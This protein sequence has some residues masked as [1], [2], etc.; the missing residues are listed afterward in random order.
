[1]SEFVWVALPY[2]AFTFLVFG[3]AVRYTVSE[4][5]WTTNPVSFWSKKQL[6]IAGT[7]IPILLYSSCS[8]GM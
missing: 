3:S 6:R 2:L 7:F 8:W 1:M 4:R 5:T